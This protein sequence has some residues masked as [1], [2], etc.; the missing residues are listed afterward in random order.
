MTLLE[1]R[2]L[3]EMYFKMHPR[4]SGELEVVVCTGNPGVPT[5]HLSKVQS[6]C[7]GS[8]WNQRFFLVYPEDNLVVEKRLA[9]PVRDVAQE[10]LESL[11][12]A[13]KTTGFKYIAKS[14]ENEWIDGFL[15]GVKMHFTGEAPEDKRCGTCGWGEP[16][17]NSAHIH[18]TMKL[19]CDPMGDSRLSASCGKDCSGWKAKEKK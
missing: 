10:R 3:I 19:P 6:A 13:H 2:N 1:L 14:R 9:R 18:C 5:N 8:D 7:P 16:V 15:E 17:E 12:Q 4:S 11:K